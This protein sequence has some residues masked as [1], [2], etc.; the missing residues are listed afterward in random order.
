MSGSLPRRYRR[1]ASGIPMAAAILLATTLGFI[2]P[3]AVSAAQAAPELHLFTNNSGTPFKAEITA[4][5]ADE[6]TLKREDGQVFHPKI[7]LF[8]GK[9]Q[10]Y[11]RL[12]AAKNAAAHGKGIFEFRTLSVQD[13]I[14]KSFDEAGHSTISKWDETYKVESKNLTFVNWAGLHFRYIIFK[15]SAHLGELPPNDFTLQRSTGTFDL[16]KYPGNGEINFAT[17]KVPMQGATLD[18]N[19]YYTNGAPNTAFDKFK[20]IWIRVYDDDENLLQEWVSDPDISKS[21]RWTFPKAAGARST[22]ARRP[23]NPDSAAARGRST[24]P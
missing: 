1:R 13:V 19:A 23:P 17:D 9:D 2:P 5:A 10:I 7:S 24:A 22:A 6:V 20:G 12:W 16:D 18:G 4:V 11:I 21:E 8:N 3:A 15:L 14:S